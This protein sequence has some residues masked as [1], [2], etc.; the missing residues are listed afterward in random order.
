MANNYSYYMKADLSQFIGEWIAI[1]DEKI[2][3]HDPK[4][5]KAFEKAKEKCPNKKPLLSKVRTEDTLIFFKA[6][7]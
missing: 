3:A 4:F 5:K 1:C 7:I 6:M 2:I